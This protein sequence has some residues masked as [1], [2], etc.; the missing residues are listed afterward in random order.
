MTAYAALLW[1]WFFG[2]PWLAYD[3]L[4]LDGTLFSIMPDVSEPM[5]ALIVAAA[6]AVYAVPLVWLYARLRALS[7]GRAL[8][9]LL[10][11]LTALAGLLLWYAADRYP[12]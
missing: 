12:F 4:V 1:L 11:L 9:V 2:V 10:L 5:Q 8:L 3:R 7:R 6:G